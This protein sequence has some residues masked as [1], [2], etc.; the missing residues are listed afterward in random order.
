MVLGAQNSIPV[1]IPEESLLTLLGSTKKKG[2]ISS[3]LRK[4]IKKATKEI[5]HYAQ[6]KAVIKTVPVKRK[7]GLAILEDK[8][9]LRSKKLAVILEPCRKAA[10]FLTSIGAEVDRLIK[11]QMKKRPYYGFL[12]DAAASVAAESVASHIQ[13][14]IDNGLQK[15]ETTT[16][17]YSPGYCDWPIDEQEKLFKFLPSSAI[18]VNLSKNHFMSPRKSIS[19]IMGICPQEPDKCSVNVCLSC[20]KPNCPHRR[21]QK[22]KIDVC[23]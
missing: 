8:V 15:D 6:P 9:Y 16:L 23:F 20:L 3:R 2:N 10:L 13:T 22:D 19:G 17:R 7:N 21:V 1:D 11:R 18:G 4:D 5:I 14:Y 12:L